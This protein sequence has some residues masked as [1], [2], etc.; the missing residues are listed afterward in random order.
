MNVPELEQMREKTIKASE[1]NEK[2]PVYC[3][4]YLNQP[5][6]KSVRDSI[7]VQIKSCERLLIK[8]KGTYERKAIEREILYL[9]LIL[10]L[11]EY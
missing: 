3:I 2:E 11:V 5:P 8:T 7:I 10:D 9:I 6:F 1:S 4:E